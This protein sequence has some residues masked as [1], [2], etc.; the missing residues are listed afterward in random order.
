MTANNKKLSAER[1]EHFKYL[2]VILK[3]DNN[4]QIDLQE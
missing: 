3:E 2:G 4:H 1:D